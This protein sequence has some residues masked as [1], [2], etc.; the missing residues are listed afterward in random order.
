[1]LTGGISIKMIHVKRLINLNFEV[2][3]MRIL[4]ADDQKD[5]RLGLRVLLEQESDI[6]IIG[7]AAGVSELMIEMQKGQPDIVLLDWELSSLR[8]ADLVPVL[9]TLCPGLRII[10]LSERPE[11]RSSALSAGVDAF[12]SKGDQPERLLETISNITCNKDESKDI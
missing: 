10:A 11:S 3:N 6:N 5:V 12:V 8:V 2:N 1:M 9:R 4:L 7:E